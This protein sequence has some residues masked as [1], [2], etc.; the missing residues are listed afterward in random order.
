MAAAM[1]PN[2]SSIHNFEQ[3]HCSATENGRRSSTCRCTRI[4]LSLKTR[5]DQCG[6]RGGEVRL[7]W[8]RR[9]TRDTHGQ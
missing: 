3:H 6:E 4:F 7:R 9:T 1:V 8:I 2:I 5:P